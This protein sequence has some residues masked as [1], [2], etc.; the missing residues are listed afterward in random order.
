M[1][2]SIILLLL[3]ILIGVL[4]LLLLPDAPFRGTDSQAVERSQAL[5]PDYSAWAHPLWEPPSDKAE[6]WLFLVQGALGFGGFVGVVWLARR[7][8][9]ALP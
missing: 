1:R 6:V 7:R 4:P 3:A 8:P 5:Q 2:R 9:K